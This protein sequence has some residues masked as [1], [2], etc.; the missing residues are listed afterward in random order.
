MA[1]VDLRWTTN[2]SNVGIVSRLSSEERCSSRTAE[3]DGSEMIGNVDAF[4]NDASLNIWHI[5]Q[6]AKASILIIANDEDYVGR[7]A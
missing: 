4:R 5:V 6:R 1:K 2:M 3:R 7:L